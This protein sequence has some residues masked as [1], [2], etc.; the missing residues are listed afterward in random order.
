LPTGNPESDN[1]R[2]LKES[3]SRCGGDL[4]RREN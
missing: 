2:Y 1:R 3:F 4:F